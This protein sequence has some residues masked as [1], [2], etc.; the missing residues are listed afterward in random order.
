LGKDLLIGVDA[1]VDEMARRELRRR[2]PLR[3]G[4]AHRAGLLVLRDF[5]PARAPAARFPR[6]ME[7]LLLETSAAGNEN[8]REPPAARRHRAFTCSRSCSAPP[9]HPA[10]RRP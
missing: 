7:M 2:V 8:G 5:L 4:F 3:G 9:L 10:D 1:R 6:P